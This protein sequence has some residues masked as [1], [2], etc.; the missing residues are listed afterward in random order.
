MTLKSDA[1]FE[2]KS[3]CCFKNWHEE[4]DK[5]LSEHFKV[6]KTFTVIG[7]FHENYITFKSTENL[8][9]MTLKSHAKFEEKLICGLAN[10]MGNLANFRKST[11][12]SHNWDFDGIFLSKLENV[13]A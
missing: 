5:F 8:S 4:F 7:P 13:C 11:R 3:I 9:L 10:D 1:K 2:E 12:R 6:S